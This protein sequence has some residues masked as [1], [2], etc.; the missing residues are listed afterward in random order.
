MIF[1]YLLLYKKITEN[2]AYLDGIAT[3]SEQNTVLTQK[4]QLETVV[5]DRISTLITSSPKYH[6]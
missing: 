4:S 3:D 5:G 6:C 1:S 2:D